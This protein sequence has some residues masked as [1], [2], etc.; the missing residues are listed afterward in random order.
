MTRYR[1]YR[2]RKCPHAKLGRVSDETPLTALC[3]R[4]GKEI[5][6]SD[7]YEKVVLMHY[8]TYVC[9]VCGKEFGFSDSIRCGSCKADLCSTDCW[10]K[11][12]F[13]DHEWEM[14]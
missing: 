2:L 8:E 12:R 9:D 3:K 14:K 5:K 10:E 7:K 1:Q 13:Q 4:C 6:L 11:H